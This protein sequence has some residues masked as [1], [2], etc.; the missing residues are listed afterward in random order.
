MGSLLR[1][2]FLLLC[3]LVEQRLRM[4]ILRCTIML[5]GPKVSIPLESHK[6]GVRVSHLSTGNYN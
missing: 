1:M 6:L 2:E 5:F 4:Y 3:R